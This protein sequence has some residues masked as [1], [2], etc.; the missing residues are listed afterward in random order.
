M[1]NSNISLTM[2]NKYKTTGTFRMAV[3]LSLKFPENDLNK[4]CKFLKDPLSCTIR[5]CEVKGTL[6]NSRP[7]R[8]HFSWFLLAKKRKVHGGYYLC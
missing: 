7:E 4:I 1:P 2:N 5:I 3:M 8:S 6:Y